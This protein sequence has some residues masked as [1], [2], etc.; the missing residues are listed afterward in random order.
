MNHS[1]VDHIP[2]IEVGCWLDTTNGKAVCTSIDANVVGYH[3]E[4]TRLS[5]NACIWVG[6]GDD[7]ANVLWR[8]PANDVSKRVAQELGAYRRI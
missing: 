4:A 1:P 8:G 5:D 7:I 2:D 6:N 3:Y